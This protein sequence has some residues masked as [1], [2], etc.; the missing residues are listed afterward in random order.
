MPCRSR[1]NTVFRSFTGYYSQ[2]GK[3]GGHWFHFDSQP[4][5][6]RHLQH[7]PGQLQVPSGENSGP[8][9]LP[10]RAR[11][12]GRL[13][14]P[15]RTRQEEK[16]PRWVRA[17]KSIYGSKDGDGSLRSEAK[18]PGIMLRKESQEEE[19]HTRPGEG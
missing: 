11:P 9:V 6:G 18:N 15:T 13:S 7:H 12:Q 14:P 17:A 2:V 19:G 10:W 5:E 8:R 16:W 1:N 4:Q 3:T